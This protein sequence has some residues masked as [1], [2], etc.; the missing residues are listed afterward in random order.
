MLITCIYYASAA[1][2]ITKGCPSVNS[3][4]SPEFGARGHETRRRLRGAETKT[5]SGFMAG[6]SG[7]G[8]LT[9]S[10]IFSRKILT[11]STSIFLKHF[12]SQ[13]VFYMD[14][15]SVTERI[16]ALWYCTCS[17]VVRVVRE[18]GR[19]LPSN[20][21]LAPGLCHTCTWPPLHFLISVTT[22]HIVYE[23]YCVLHLLGFIYFYR[24]YF[25]S[26]RRRWAPVKGAL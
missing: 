26:V 12:L 8:S 7:H 16:Y 11:D 24:F 22:R 17:N 4:A 23:C 5:S 9:F 14:T 19:Q 6:Q 3:V 2:V 25:M 21:R 18:C 10:H 1:S 13:N 15:E 20:L